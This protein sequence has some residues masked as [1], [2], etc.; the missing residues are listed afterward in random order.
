MLS[1][2]LAAFTRRAAAIM[3]GPHPRPEKTVGKSR[4]DGRHARSPRNGEF[5]LRNELILRNG[6]FPFIMVN[7]PLF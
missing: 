4:G 3:V 7:F 1:A 2:P 6:E 5:I